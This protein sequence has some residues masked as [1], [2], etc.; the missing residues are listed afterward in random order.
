MRFVLFCIV[1]LLIGCTLTC[2]LAAR[3]A[4][5]AYA[6]AGLDTTI[7]QGLL[8]LAR[9]VRPRP[10]SAGG[11]VE[12]GV[13]CYFLAND[14]PAGR[15]VFR[16]YGEEELAAAV[17]ETLTCDG[18]TGNDFIEAAWGKPIRW[19]P[20]H[21][22]DPGTL[23]ETVGDKQIFTIR[24]EGPGYFSDW[25]GY[26]NL[27]WRSWPFTTNSVWA[28]KRRRATS[29]RSNCPPSTV[30]ASL[31]WPTTRCWMASTKRWGWLGASTQPGGWAQ[32]RR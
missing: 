16:L 29:T 4:A 32:R 24:H 19:P 17:E 3:P 13:N 22:E 9:P 25:S 30:T 8:L 6:V 11:F 23:V 12:I 28:T 2:R 18:V 5:I 14:A 15:E 31:T 20:L 10:R 26:S 27:A 1:L 21:F 7:E